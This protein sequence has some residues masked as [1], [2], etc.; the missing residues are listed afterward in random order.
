VFGGFA[1]TDFEAY[2]EHKWRSNAFSLERLSVK[3]KLVALGREL[4][5][6]ARAADGSP[7]HCEPSTEHPALWNQKRVEAQ[8]LFFSRDRSTRDALDRVIERSRS[9]ASLIEDPSPQRSHLVL[10]ISIDA[11]RLSVALRLHSDATIDRRNLEQKTRDAPL[12]ASLLDL[13]H[14]LPSA[15][16]ASVGT[17][18]AIPATGLDERALAELLSELGRPLGAGESRWL[19]IGRELPR[20][21]VLALGAELLT[22]I[23]TAMTLL[24]PLFHFV[25]WTPENDHIELGRELRAEAEAK[26]H[27][28][29]GRNDRVRVVS[30][31]FS[32]RVGVIQELDAHGGIKVLI[33][34]IPIL[35]DAGDVVKI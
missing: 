17:L 11:V 15:F 30:G 4:A 35:L 28:G 1:E 3:E 26:R 22:Q 31:M 19:R 25:A 34:R 27:R 6:A 18:P 33:G 23:R 32:G 21:E 9:L 13:L 20:S 2:A 12:R 10:A 16:G 24:L 29:L 7:L 5:S 14:G 8:H